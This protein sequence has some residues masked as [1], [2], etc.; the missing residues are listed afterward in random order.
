M[1]IIKPGP[2][3]RKFQLPKNAKIHL[4][5]N[6][7]LFHLANPDTPLQLTFQYE[8]EEENKFEIEWIL[9]ENTNQYLVKW[10]GYNNNENI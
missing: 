7:A 6:V 1:I 4:V 9:D 2:A 10:K 5:F 3:I 8:P